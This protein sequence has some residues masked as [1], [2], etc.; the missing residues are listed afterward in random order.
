MKEIDEKGLRSLLAKFNKE[1]ENKHK[2]TSGK[3][4]F[5]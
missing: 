3:F 5:N 1:R 2:I 4:E